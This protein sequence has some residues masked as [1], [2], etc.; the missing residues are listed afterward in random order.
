MMRHAVMLRGK[1]TEQRAQVESSESES[2]AAAA[3]RHA[4]KYMLEACL[5]SKIYAVLTLT[6]RD[7]WH[8]VEGAR[9]GFELNTFASN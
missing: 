5:L 2:A 9:R 6:M 1:G 7:T 3:V 8:E 4:L